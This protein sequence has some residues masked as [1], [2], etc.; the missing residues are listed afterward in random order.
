M[1]NDCCG[2]LKVVTKNKDVL[3]RVKKIFRYE[4]E[5]YCLSRVRDFQDC[6]EMY[7]DGEYF[8]QDFYI[9]GAWNCERFI[10][11]GH[12]PDK[13]ICLKQEY[14]DG[15]WVYEYGTAHFTDLSHL[16][17]ILGFGC[18]FWT[19]EPGMMFA[20]HGLVNCDGHYEYDTSDYTISYPEKENGEPDYDNPIEECGFG[21]TWREWMYADEIYGDNAD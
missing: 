3:E 1:A 5:E 4:D 18:E 15:K 10:N 19:E 8:V 9:D 6:G 12:L 14:V 20:E 2:C 11:N 21:D 7:E 17:K 16:A 13:K